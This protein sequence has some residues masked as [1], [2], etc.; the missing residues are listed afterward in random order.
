MMLRGITNDNHQDVWVIR[1]DGNEVPKTRYIGLFSTKEKCR[2]AFRKEME[3]AWPEGWER[4]DT[5]PSGNTKEECIQ[6]M[7]FL[8]FH[9]LY[10][11]TGIKRGIDGPVIKPHDSHTKPKLWVM[12]TDYD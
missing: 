11:M 4:D 8:D 6:E 1:I 10:S 9:N 7:Q 3:K 2:N 12:L 5:I